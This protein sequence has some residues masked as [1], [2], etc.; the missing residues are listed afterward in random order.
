VNRT[1]KKE[2]AF[3]LQG[4]ALAPTLA[5]RSSRRE[6][7]N[8]KESTMSRRLNRR[9]F[10]QSS[11]VSATAAGFWLTGGV[12]ETHAAQGANE[13]LNIAVIG[14]G[15]QGGSDLGN[16]ASQNI[17]ALC[18]VDDNRAGGSFNKYPK[19][20][21]YKDFRVMLEKQKDIQAVVVST[22]D[23]QHAIASIMAMR[24]GKHVY[25]QKPLT[26]D[27]WE[28]RLMGEVAA[29][30][31]VATQ[32]GNQ[33][34]AS[35]GLRAGAETIR[36]GAIGNV[37]E[38]HVWTDRPGMYWRQGH[39]E[40]PKETP[41]VPKTLDWDLW[42]G[43]AP[44]RPYNPAY[45]PFAWRGWWDFGTGALG[46]MGCHIMNLSFMAL[47][48]GP[49][50]S[51]QAVLTTDRPVNNESPPNG[52][53][54]TYEFPARGQRPAVRMIWYESSRP[55]ADLFHGQT[56][57]AGGSLFV[58]SKGKLY[59]RDDYGSNNI[60]LPVENFRDFR[61]PA[62]TIPRAQGGHHAEWIRACKGGPP[63]MSNFTSYS[64]PLTEMV[65]LGNVAI[66]VG[67]RIVWNSE[68]LQAVDLAAAN[69]Y[70]RRE[71]RKGWALTA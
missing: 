45:V 47:Q 5:D 56:I 16:V 19:A 43:T 29:K 35:N 54:V 36:S 13:R 37:S 41:P 7:G 1:A 69:Q 11:A 33:G 22:P 39:A 14:C 60:L 50:S 66:R 51:V 31:R 15:G 62:P 3:L 67:K 2:P 40:R 9:K 23:H 6:S 4:A 10:L 64:G 61:A 20:P 52:L 30:M 27:V 46:D 21:K 53:R 34:T 71:Y 12:T 18:D 32:M 49:P 59:S 17:V 63:A 44:T 25:C 42:I 68:K 28:A 57:S 48:L 8:I 65:L 26:H 58:G 70:I 38:V 55:A 24:M